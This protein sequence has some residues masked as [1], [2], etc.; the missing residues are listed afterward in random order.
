MRALGAFAPSRVRTETRVASDQ[1]RRRRERAVRLEQHPEHDLQLGRALAA[2]AGGFQHSPRRLRNASIRFAT[3]ARRGRSTLPSDGAGLSASPVAAWR[4]GSRLSS[5][6][7]IL[8]R[9]ELRLL[10]AFC[11]ERRL[12]LGLSSRF[13]LRLFLLQGFGDRIDLR[14]LFLL[15]LVSAWLRAWLSGGGGGSALAASSSFFSAT[16]AVESSTGFGS[17]IFSTSG[18]GLSCPW[19]RSSRPRSSRRIACPR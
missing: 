15:G 11:C 7:A 3:I 6:A 2:P 18:F 14:R 4:C 19:A 17:P 16:L 13:L 9:I 1:L 10:L 12:G 5:S 8:C